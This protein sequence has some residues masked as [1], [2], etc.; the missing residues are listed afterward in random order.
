MLDIERKAIE[1]AARARTEALEPNSV[2]GTG[3]VSVLSKGTDVIPTDGIDGE[4]WHGR[5]PV[6]TVGI[7]SHAEPAAN[8]ISS[9]LSVHSGVHVETCDSEPLEQHSENVQHAL[10]DGGDAVAL[11]L[12]E[13]RLRRDVGTPGV[14]VVPPPPSGLTP[15]GHAQAWNWYWDA[16][17]LH[18]CGRPWPYPEPAAVT[19]ILV[20]LVSYQR[21]PC[22]RLAQTLRS[23]RW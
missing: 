12:Y 21:K 23:L 3:I 16:W 11:A 13:R 1:A 7:D 20:L 2:S 8:G 4:N 6:A 14:E 10:R 18:R 9:V 17:P 15:D 5:S 19:S 22:A